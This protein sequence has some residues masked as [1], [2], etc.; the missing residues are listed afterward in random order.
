MRTADYL[1]IPVIALVSSWDNL[2]SKAFF[3]FSLRRLIVWNNVLKNEAISLFDFPENKI[4]VT[5]VPRYDL[6][7]RK[8]D[9]SKSNG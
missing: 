7:F 5:G 1:K 8:K 4:S 9:I 6:F 3:P 2:T